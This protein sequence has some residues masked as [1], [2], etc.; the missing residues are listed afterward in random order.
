MV[1]KKDCKIQKTN[2]YPIHSLQSYLFHNFI[3]TSFK[4][5]WKILLSWSCALKYFAET[6]FCIF[7]GF[8]NVMLKVCKI[9]LVIWPFTW[10]NIWQ[11]Q[12]RRLCYVA[13]SNK[14]L[15]PFFHFFSF[16][17]KNKTSE[18]K[19]VLLA[20]KKHKMCLS[21]SNLTSWQDKKFCLMI[22][23]EMLQFKETLHP[24]N[25]SNI[26]FLTWKMIFSSNDSRKKYQWWHCR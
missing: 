26:Q 2:H 25:F 17:C 20:C 12:L 10:A 4:N 14:T 3:W 24:I 21:F 5:L 11:Y 23:A 8:I 15:K 19:F 13:Y 6:H 9:W 1:T 18:L 16:D 7:S 22:C